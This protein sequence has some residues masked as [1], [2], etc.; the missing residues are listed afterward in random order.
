[1]ILSV[2]TKPANQ[3]HP[4]HQPPATGQLLQCTRSQES[5]SS[6]SVDHPTETT[7]EAAE[8]RVDLVS[9]QYQ[10]RLTSG[11]ESA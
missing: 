3:L 4:S 9:E 6:G 5:R 8:S 7:L 10:I 2:P 11:P 1:M